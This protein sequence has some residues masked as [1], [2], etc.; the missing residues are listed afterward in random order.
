MSVNI[1]NYTFS[2][3]EWFNAILFFMLS[4]C[5]FLKITD[6]LLTLLT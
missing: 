1:K 6:L 2:K 5:G 4:L 3:K